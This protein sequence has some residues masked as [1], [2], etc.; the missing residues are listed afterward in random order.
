M[1]GAPVADA[2]FR[3]YGPFASV[4]A[5]QNA[6]LDENTLMQTVRTDGPGT[7]FLWNAQLVPGL[8]H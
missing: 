6:S 1:N 2:E 5:A 7:G 4:Q 8:R 3:L